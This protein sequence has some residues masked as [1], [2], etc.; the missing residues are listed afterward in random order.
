MEQSVEHVRAWKRA[1]VHFEPSRSCATST[2][3]QQYLD[4]LLL[5]LG[6]SPYRKG[7]PVAELFGRYGAADYRGVGEAY[8]RSRAGAREPRR[9]V[10]VHT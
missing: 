4:V 7:N 2:R 9:P 1:H 5:D 3:F 10:A 8:R 6:V